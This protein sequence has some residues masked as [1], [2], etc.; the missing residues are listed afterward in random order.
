MQ[1]QEAA[2]IQKLRQQLDENVRAKPVPDLSRPFAINWDLVKP[3]TKATPF[4][5]RTDGR[6]GEY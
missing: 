2:E 4:R 3:A 5:L 6:F 1:A